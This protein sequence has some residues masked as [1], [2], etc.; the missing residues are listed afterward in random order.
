MIVTEASSQIIEFTRLYL[1]LFYTFVAAF[2][3]VRIITL[4][5]ATGVERVYHGQKF[6]ANWWHHQIFDVFRVLI[7]LTCVLRFFFPAMD[8]Y[9]GL[10]PGASSGI[11]VL[12]GDLVLTFGFASTILVH[13][14]MGKVWASGVN[15]RGPSKLI[16]SGLYRYSR[17]PIFIAILVSQVGFV[18]AL[19]SVF[20]VVC[21]VVGVTTILRQVTVEEQ[22]LAQVFP[23]TYPAY[24]NAVPR[25]V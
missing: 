9:L 20:S 14:Y 22:H 21:L 1:A 19:P 13:F 6:S 7:W 24:R 23:D 8:G 11:V 3:T 18:L 4:K 17:N 25:W 10:L 16:T 15:Q 2:Y 5:R 12:I